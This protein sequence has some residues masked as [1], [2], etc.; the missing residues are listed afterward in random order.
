MYAILNNIADQNNMKKTMTIFSLCLALVSFGQ[1][2]QVVINAKI[3]GLEAGR[4][5]YTRTFNQFVDSVQTSEGK[6]TIKLP[7]Q[8]GDGD[9]YLLMIDKKYEEN[10]NFMILY[11]DR[12]LVNM[13]GDGPNFK[14]VRFSGSPFVKDY[15][16]FESIK[17][18]DP[19]FKRAET[20][21]NQY[22][23]AHKAQDTV[24]MTQL[25]PKLHELDS[26]RTVL[27]K[28]WIGQ[29]P[30]SP[31]STYLLYQELRYK[32]TLPDQ[33]AILSKL[34]SAA[35]D[36]VLAKQMYHS[37]EVD[38]TT[39]IGRAAL[40]FTQTD[41]SGNPVALKDYR[42]KYVLLDFW[43]SWCGPCRAENPNVVA[44]Y[45]KFRDKNF[46]VLS[47]SLDQK[48]DSW[49]NAIHKDNLRWTNLSDLGAWNNAVARQYDI[50]AIPA[51]F[52]IDPDGKIVAKDLHN[53][54]LDKKL[55]EILK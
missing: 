19:V 51:N 46:T 10:N 40:D 41:T 26:V 8:K 25:A 12:G 32:L 14:D 42:G 1:K 53:E 9:V 35:K 28:K 47:V 48:K 31:I 2:D 18:K 6:F 29:H 24:L 27:A 50:Q 5:V 15:A 33:E 30:S 34:S 43:A 16:D 39:G 21:Y 36:N 17:K 54:E 4:W 45:N 13:S 37:I 22:S 52:L 55:S 44:A 20:I 3:K 11:L 38:K 23:A 7:I 49:I